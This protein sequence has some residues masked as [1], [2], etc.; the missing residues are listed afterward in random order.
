MSILLHAPCQS[1][2]VED[3][4]EEIAY[5]TGDYA[6]KVNISVLCKRTRETT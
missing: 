6:S 2:N 3:G 4:V 5:I 1:L